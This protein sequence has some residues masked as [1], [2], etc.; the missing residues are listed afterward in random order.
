MSDKLCVKPRREFGDL[1]L[2]PYSSH[3]VHQ[4]LQLL[5]KM[6]LVYSGNITDRLIFLHLKSFNRILF[7][8]VYVYSLRFRQ[9][10]TSKLA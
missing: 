1:F 5:L 8:C 2:N 6:F 10:M 3:F 9:L 7:V 4:L